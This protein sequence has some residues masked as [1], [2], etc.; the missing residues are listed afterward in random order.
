MS[1]SGRI[2]SMCRD[3]ESIVD[4]AYLICFCRK[5]TPPEREHFLTQLSGASKNEKNR[6]VEDL[7]WAL[8]NSPEFSWNH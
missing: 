3:D 6:V 4:T 2:A 5:P 1:T 7:F 8:F